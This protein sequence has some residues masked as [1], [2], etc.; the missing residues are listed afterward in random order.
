MSNFTELL[1]KALVNIWGGTAEQLSNRQLIET[2]RSLSRIRAI[3]RFKGEHGTR[4]PSSMSYKTKSSRAGYLAAFGERHAYLS[5]LQLRSIEAKL[6]NAIPQPHGRRNILTITSL[7][8]GACIELYGLCLFLIGDSNQTL[9][10]KFNAVGREREW[11]P[12]RN[13]VITRVLKESFLKLDVD[14]TDINIDLRKDSVATLARYYDALIDTD[15]LLIYN[16]MNEIP[17]QFAKYIRKNIKFLL[18]IFQRPV[19]I[20]LMEPASDRAEPRINWLKQQ[21]TQ[22]TE[23][24][25]TGKDRLFAFDTLPVHICMSAPEQCLNYRLFGT[26][27][28]GSKPTFETTIRRSYLAS[29]KKPTSPISIEQVTRQLANLDIKR[30]RRGSFLPR[31]SRSGQQSSFGNIDDRWKYQ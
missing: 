20:L 1:E 15:I 13:Y 3:Y 21:F 25:E 28:D 14:L 24:I 4:Q 5:Y 10:I 30:G 2:R 7:G 17:Q 19:L 12:N 29:L 6:P 23:I 22:E 26:R 16:V 9:Q 11:G 18:D 8:A 27:M 31:H